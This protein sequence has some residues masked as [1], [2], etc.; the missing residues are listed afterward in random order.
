MPVF[1]VDKNRN[2]TVMSNHH[3]QNI[4]LSLKAKGLL[5]QMLSLPE[6][7]DYTLFGLTKINNDGVDGIRAAVNELERQGYLTRRRIRNDKGQLTVT[8]YTIL[9]HP[10]SETPVLENPMLDKPTLE[11]PTQAKPTLGNP[12]QLNTKGLKTN[13]VSPKEKNTHAENINPSI[14]PAMPDGSYR[15]PLKE[16]DRMDEMDSY[17]ELIMDNIEYDIM[18]DRYR[19]DRMDEI[20]EVM[21]DAICSKRD[22]I[23]IGGDE[24][25]VEVVK[26]RLLKLTSSHVEYVFDCIDK[27]TTKVHNIKAY[28]LTTLYNAPATIDHYYTTLVNHDMYGSL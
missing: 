24:Y 22:Y 18:A 20:V 3:L 23:R 25:P 17:R 8:E 16:I 1:R 28:L 15:L 12:T 21:L 10:V 6:T 14:Y 19:K 27:N 26:S 5:S 4:A 13:P 11:N 9:E 7:W 2:Y